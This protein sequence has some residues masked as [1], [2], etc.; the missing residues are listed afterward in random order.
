MEEINQNFYDFLKKSQPIAFLASFSMLIAVF[1]FPNEGLQLVYQNAAMAAFMFVLAFVFS[2]L[3]QLAI[4]SEKKDGME[5]TFI[6]ELIR[7]GTYFFLIIGIAY[8]VLIVLEFKESF[9]ALPEI[10]VGW[11]SLFIGVAALFFV[12]NFYSAI[13]KSKDFVV[14]LVRMFSLMTGIIFVGAIIIHGASKIF[15]AVFEI[16]IPF[17]IELSLLITTVIHGSSFGIVVLISNFLSKKATGKYSELPKL[18]VK[19]Q[20]RIS[21][22]YVIGF[23]TILGFFIASSLLSLEELFIPTS[24]I[25]LTDTISIEDSIELSLNP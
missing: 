6:P 3:S 18:Y 13:K 25:I 5:P 9:P 1:A 22:I 21:R 16:N 15:G 11:A 24:E 17:I 12:K 23:L 7:Y 19:K 14:L 10:V 8:L 4:Y 2:L 20:S